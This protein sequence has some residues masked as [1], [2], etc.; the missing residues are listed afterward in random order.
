M[1]LFVGPPPLWLTAKSLPAVEIAEAVA[2]PYVVVPTSLAAEPRVAELRRSG[3]RLVLSFNLYS[4]AAKPDDAPIGWFAQNQWGIDKPQRSGGTLTLANDDAFA[5][6]LGRAKAF[7]A[8]TDDW[9]GVILSVDLRTDQMSFRY[10]ESERAR[11][12]AALGLDPIDFDDP[13]DWS[14]EAAKRSPMP[15]A[16]LNY[17]TAD[18]RARAR[19]VAQAIAAPFAAQKKAVALRVDPGLV[20]ATPERHMV[21]YGDWTTMLDLPGLSELWIPAADAAKAGGVAAIPGASR[22]R[23]GLFGAGKDLPTDDRFDTIELRL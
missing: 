2:R 16:L 4:F 23:L 22:L 5:D 10:D 11:A 1:I 15:A 7:G 13:L 14:P 12:V 3:A 6:Q 21:A 8:R 17:L 18:G 9:A 20:G 19:Q